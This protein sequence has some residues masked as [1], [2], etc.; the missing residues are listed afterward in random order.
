MR[1]TSLPPV[2]SAP[3]LF[4]DALKKGY[5]PPVEALPSG[6]GKAAMTAPADDL[7]ARLLGEYSAYRRK[8]ARELYDEQG[9]SER[10]IARQS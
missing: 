9:E 2:R 1:S 6:G 4:K 10:E 8:E 3:A 7:K 5:A